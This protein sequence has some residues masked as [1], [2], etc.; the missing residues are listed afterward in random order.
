[1]RSTFC[2]RRTTT[3]EAY[4]TIVLDPPAFAKRKD[5]VEAALRGYKEL[6]LR[7]LR[8][9]NPGRIS[10]HVQLLVPPEQLAVP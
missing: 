2:A 5:A 10:V 9:L 1:M 7:A 6:N 3:G 4:D 8:I